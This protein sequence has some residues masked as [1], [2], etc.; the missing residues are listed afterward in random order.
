MTS[1]MPFA[2]PDTMSL[3]AAQVAPVVPAVAAQLRLVPGIGSGPLAPAG[4]GGPAKSKSAPKTGAG[5]SASCGAPAPT[6]APRGGPRKVMPVHCE[7]EARLGR[8]VVNEATGHSYFKSGVDEAFAAQLLCALEESPLPRTPWIQHTDH[9]YLLPTGL[10]VRTTSH[11]PYEEGQDL[12]ADPPKFV[13]NHTIKT[14][15]SSGTYHWRGGPAA[16]EECPAPYEIRVSLKNEEPVFDSELQERVDEL[17]LVRVKQRRTF[18]HTSKDDT[19]PTWNIDVT[20]VWQSDTYLG[21]MEALQSGATPLY[22]VEVECVRPVE[23]IRRRT[24]D[25]AA[26]SLLLKTLDLFHA[27]GQACPGSGYTLHESKAG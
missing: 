15:V 22:E 13:V 5:A 14:V 23:Y 24:V 10:Q 12:V 18:M 1:A 26:L 11:V 9:F 25:V 8:T 7:V 20:L 16:T 4:G 27:C 6:P 3:A 19:A 21:A 17:N 2:M